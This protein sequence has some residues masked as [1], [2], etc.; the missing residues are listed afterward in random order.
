MYAADTHVPVEQSKAEIER[1]LVKYRADKFASGWGNGT[2]RIGFQLNERFIQ[3]TLPIPGEADVKLKR[4][5]F[6]VARSAQMESLIAKATRARWRALL[7]CLKAK[8]EAVESGI[9]TFETEFLPY[10][11]LPGGQTVAEAV[12]PQIEQAYK[13]GG[14]G[15]LT[16][17]LPG[18]KN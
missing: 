9:T 1:L 15:E 8:L 3:F 5:R 7:L 10:T 14:C 6:G 4:R 11:V 12:A 18:P 13:S 17:A 2:A 16:L